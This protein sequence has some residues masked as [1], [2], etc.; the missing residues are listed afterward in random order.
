MS[1]CQYQWQEAGLRVGWMGIHEQ[2]CIPPMQ[3]NAQE[4]CHR[5][6]L[7]KPGHVKLPH[8]ILNQHA[9]GNIERQKGPEKGLSLQRAAGGAWRMAHGECYTAH[10][11][12][13]ARIFS[14]GSCLSVIAPTHLYCQLEQKLM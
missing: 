13:P 4:G 10:G 5:S 12:L 3:N 1:V 14:G 6:N 9:W 8:A 2:T 11:G 7:P